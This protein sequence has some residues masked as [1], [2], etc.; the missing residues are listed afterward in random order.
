MFVDLVMNTSN[1]NILIINA[2]RQHKVWL[3]THTLES[4]CQDSKASSAQICSLGKVSQPMFLL[5]Q[6]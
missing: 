3:R 5:P 1:L 2:L 4:D 6:L